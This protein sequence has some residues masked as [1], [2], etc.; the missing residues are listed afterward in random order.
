[1]DSGR[2]HNA[3]VT[4]ATSLIPTD[5]SLRI[6]LTRLSALVLG[7]TGSTRHTVDRKELINATNRNQR[8][9]EMSEMRTRAERR[10]AQAKAK[11][12]TKQF[13]KTILG[14]T[15]DT[16]A[17]IGVWT[18]T[19]RRPCSCNLCRFEWDGVFRFKGLK[20]TEVSYELDGQ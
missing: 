15:D 6:S 19:H 13:M 10:N 1:M 9:C 3:Q 4:V 16:E 17:R 5:N 20:T 18:S 7:C 12:K 2:D 14:R 11:A 8:R